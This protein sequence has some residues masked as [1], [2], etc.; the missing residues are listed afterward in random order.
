[1]IQC[2][3]GTYANETG[4][5]QCEPCPEGYECPTASQQPTLCRRGTYSSGAAA[6]CTPCPSGLFA[7]YTGA[8]E[9]E[10]CP[11]GYACQVASNRPLVCSAGTFRYVYIY[12]KFCCTTAAI[13]NLR[14]TMYCPTPYYLLDFLSALWAQ[15]HVHPVHSAIILLLSLRAAYHALLVCRQKCTIFMSIIKSC[16]HLAGQFCPDAAVPPQDCLSGSY[17]LGN[18]TGCL[19]CPSGYQCPLTNSSPEVCPPGYYS[20]AKSVSCLP[21]SEG[22]ACPGNGTSERIRYIVLWYLLHSEGDSSR[23]K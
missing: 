5:E 22:Y 16:V 6:S 21:C 18:A 7:N 12:S 10:S 4:Q 20:P 13:L 9:C 8:V 17:S 3:D 11:A 1:M 14:C 19:N 23:V 2:P 15:V